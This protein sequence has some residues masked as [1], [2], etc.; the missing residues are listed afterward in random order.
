MYS[1]HRARASNSTRHY[2]SNSRFEMAYS[3]SRERSTRRASLSSSR[4]SMG[5][6]LHATTTKVSMPL[7]NRPNRQMHELYEYSSGSASNATSACRSQCAWSAASLSECRNYREPVCDLWTSE[8]EVSDFSM[9][10]VGSQGSL[11]QTSSANT[12]IIT[13]ID[14]ITCFAVAVPLSY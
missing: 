4:P 2:T 14:C 8:V 12:Y 5:S 13:I 11:S 10:L 3:S 9:D 7:I 1:Q 6:V